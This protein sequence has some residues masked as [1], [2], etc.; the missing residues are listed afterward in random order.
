[1]FTCLSFLTGNRQFFENEYKIMIVDKMLSSNIA[2]SWSILQ[3]NEGVILSA[4]IG[5]VF[6]SSVYDVPCM[7]VRVL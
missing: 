2:K 4:F 6:V 7:Y 5:E 3:R 1:M